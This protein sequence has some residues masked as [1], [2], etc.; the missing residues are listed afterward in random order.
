VRAAEAGQR[1]ERNGGGESCNFNELQLQLKWQ[2]AREACERA[3]LRGLRGSY[4]VP[5]PPRVSLSDLYL[6]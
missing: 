6:R 2:R 4:V 5:V 3:E 1:S